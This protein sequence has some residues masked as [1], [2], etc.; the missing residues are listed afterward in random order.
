MYAK[1]V[2]GVM[3]YAPKDKGS[4]SNYNK[5]EQLL[6]ADGYLPVVNFT[7]EENQ[8]IDGWEEVDGMITPVIAFS[9][10]SVEDMKAIR[11]GELQTKLAETD[12]I[13]CKII[14]ALDYSEQA[15][16]KEKYADVIM[17]RRGWRAELNDLLGDK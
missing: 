11:I 15:D 3:E 5:N 17:Q 9:E 14:E 4:I 10:P 13:A 16:L 6:L 7:L 2:N 12:Y 1:I 8:Y